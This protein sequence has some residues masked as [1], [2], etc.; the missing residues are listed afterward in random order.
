MLG[1]N[2]LYY[3]KRRK[4]RILIVVVILILIAL[5]SVRNVYNFMRM[6]NMLLEET[7]FGAA[8]Y[9]IGIFNSAQFVMFFGIPVSFSILVADLIRGDMDENT[10]QFILA[11]KQNR[12]AYLIEKCKLIVAFAILFTIMI[13]IVAF[14]VS[15]L[16]KLPFAAENYYYL[17]QSFSTALNTFM[18]V[19]L[20]FICGL[21]FIGFMVLTLSMYVKNAGIAVGIMILLGFIH[22]VFFV[23]GQNE[24]LAWLPFSQYIVGQYSNHIPYGLDVSYFDSVFAVLYMLVGSIILLAMTMYKMRKMEI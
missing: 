4:V 23:I 5:F 3:A 12:A 9:I 6:A 11:R 2:L 19:V 16:W 13:L 1:T 22:N 15:L 7:T 20:I 17:F 10:M 14:V 21:C 24:I 18:V 8:D